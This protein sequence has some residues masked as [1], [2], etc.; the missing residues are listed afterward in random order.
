MLD[1][2]TA[3]CKEIRMEFNN[4]KCYCIVFGKCAKSSIDPMRLYMDIIYWAESVKYLGVHINGGKNLPFDIHSFRRSFYAAFNRI[5]S[6]AKALKEP[7]QL[8]L[9]ESYCLP[10]L[11][12]AADAVTYNKQQVH[13]LN[14]CWNTKYQTVFNFNRWES[15][16]SFINGSGKLIL[17]YILKVC[18]VK[19]YFHLLYAANSL[20]SDL[21]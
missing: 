14:V 9:F 1:T 20:L 10:L 18:K 19:F 12:F 2:G 21:F 13:D 17:Q 11:M 8:A 4:S 5:H 3:V 16:K 6:H 15:I 7:V